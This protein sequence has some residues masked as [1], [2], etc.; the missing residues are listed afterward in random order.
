MICHHLKIEIVS[1]YPNSVTALGLLGT[2]KSL[3]NGA[4]YPI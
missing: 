2:G 3:L 1:G 4:P